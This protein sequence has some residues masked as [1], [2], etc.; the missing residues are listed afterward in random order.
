MKLGYKFNIGKV[1][2]YETGLYIDS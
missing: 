2:L 1:L